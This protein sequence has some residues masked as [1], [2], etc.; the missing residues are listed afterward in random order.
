MLLGIA[1]HGAMSFI[2]DAGI[3]WG[4]QDPTSSGRYGI[5]LA[6]IHGWRMPLFFLISGFFTAMLWRK[7]GLRALFV[8]RFKRIFVPMLLALFTIVP[9]ILF[10]SGYVRLRPP[11]KSTEQTSATNQTKSFEGIDVFAA[12]ATNDLATL[13]RYLN[14]GGD[15]EAKDENGSTPLHVACFFG[16]AEAA[17]LLLKADAS[18]DATNNDGLRAEQLLAIDWGTTAFIAQLVQLPVEKSKVLAGREVIAQTIGEKTGRSIATNSANRGSRSA[19]AE[20]L[21]GFLFYFP[22]FH[23]LW[24]LWFLCWF[25]CGFV[26]I[27]KLLKTLS[28]PAVPSF[29]L[30][31]TVRYIWLIPLTVIPQYFMA[32]GPHAYGPDTSVGLLPFPIVFGYYA[33]FFGFGA[34]YYGADDQKHHVGKGFWWTLAFAVLILFPMGLSIKGP[35]T[36]SQRIVFS[37]LQ[38][39]YTWTMSFGMIE[40]FH[41]ICSIRRPWVRYLSDASYW[42]YLAH[43]PVVIYLQFLVRDLTLPSI[44]K[45]VFVCSATTALL[46]VIYQL[47]VRNTWVGALLNGRRYPHWNHQPR[48]PAEENS[49]PPDLLPKSNI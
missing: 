3:I 20:N 7:R 36:T 42:L 4:V 47:C 23:H 44:V 11:T 14:E 16:R 33:I 21:M 13:T 41:R 26:L 22:V 43:P 38:V 17:D 48:Q 35:E 31:S 29:W 18:L 27:G 37:V 9:L 8:H 10:V 46:L 25:V 49:G 45:Y 1:L 30:T 15:V 12:T 34:L 32:R 6:S 5:L 19:K 24:F 39:S 2:P 40:L 28:I